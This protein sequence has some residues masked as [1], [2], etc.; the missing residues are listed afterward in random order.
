[1]KHFHFFAIQCT[2]GSGL[3]TIPKLVHSLSS[4]L[5]STTYIA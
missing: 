5:F 4:K 1:M 2:V 3:F